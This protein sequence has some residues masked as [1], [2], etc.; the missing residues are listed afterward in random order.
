MGA[1]GVVESVSS[2]PGVEKGLR[3]RI[4][5]KKRAHAQVGLTGAE[6][7]PLAFSS[8]LISLSNET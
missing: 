6:G 1:L 2:G 4:T 8:T 7:R 5:G 3:L